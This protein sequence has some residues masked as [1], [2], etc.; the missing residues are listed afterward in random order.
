[1]NKANADRHK[2]EVT[3]IG[4]TACGRHGC[5]V[6]GSVVDFQKGEQ[7]KNMDYSLSAALNYNMPENPRVLLMYDIM[8]QY[9]VHLLDRFN[10][11]PYLRMPPGIQIYKGIGLFHVHGHQD[12]C[13]PRYAPNFIPG[14]GQVEGEIIETLWAPLIQIAGSTRAMSKAHRQETLDDHMADS[15]FKKMIKTGG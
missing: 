3:G 4:A 14:A 13:Y 1:M 12:S 15:N 8:C 7:Q 10:R 5:F 11:S 6:P 9:G 2:L